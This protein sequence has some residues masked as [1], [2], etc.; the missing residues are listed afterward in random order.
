MSATPCPRRRAG[1]RPTSRPRA[2]GTS[3][4]RCPCW[5]TRGTR[6]RGRRSASSTRSTRQPRRSTPTRC[7]RGGRSCRR[8]RRWATGRR[9]PRRRRRSL[10]GGVLAGASIWGKR[11]PVGEG[12]LLVRER[13]LGRTHSAAGSTVAEW[14]AV[15]AVAPSTTSAAAASAATKAASSGLN[16]GVL[17]HDEERLGQDGQSCQGLHRE[18]FSAGYNVVE[19]YMAW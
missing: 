8:R 16:V 4:C 10:S 14:P 2:S 18:C 3:R 6:C 19:G 11:S 1:R 9:S 5:S 7:T 12:A 17:S 13:G 15:A